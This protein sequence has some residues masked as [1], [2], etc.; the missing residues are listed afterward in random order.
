MFRSLENGKVM[1]DVIGRMMGLEGVGEIV[2]NEFKGIVE[3]KDIEV[4]I[5]TYW[6]LIIRIKHGTLQKYKFV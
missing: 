4:L 5:F 3:K 2:E 1:E 6:F